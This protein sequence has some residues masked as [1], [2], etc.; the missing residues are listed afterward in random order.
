MS[1]APTLFANLGAEE[2]EGW[3]RMAAHPR[4]RAAARLWCALFPAGA[5]A[6]GPAAPPCDGLQAPFDADSERAA[7]SFCAAAEG[8]LV[9][10]LATAEARACAE[11]AGLA[12]AGPGPEAVAR[13]HDK[14]FALAAARTAGLGPAE[15]ADAALALAPEELGAADAVRCRI[16]AE[17]AGW[18]VPLRLRFVLKPRLGTSG[19]GRLEGR[20]GR[21]DPE[22]LR[23]ALPRFRACGGCVVEPWLERLADLSAQ[24]WIAPDG[25]VE[26]LGTLEQVMT[27]GGVPL[28]H[29]GEL[30]SDGAVRSGSRW[31]PELRAA[32]LA[33][34]AAAAGAGF[35]GPCGVDAFAYRDSSGAEQLRPVV[36]FNARVTAGISALGVL[37]RARALGRWER[38]R[39][40]YLGVAPA[41]PELPPSERIELLA[42]D[43]ETALWLG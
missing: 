6:V 18:P 35:A 36:E 10:W 3:P 19:R 29:R 28:G 23:G 33:L 37:A 17:V 43:P 20:E 38:S 22:A 30:G 31:D 26:L 11:R 9:P 7:F 32:A 42:G 34:G 39:R 1:A 16:E 15:L 13:V 25:T 27:P 5:R 8:R 2:G 4:V 14:A 12:L 24:L 41:E 21:L 40:F